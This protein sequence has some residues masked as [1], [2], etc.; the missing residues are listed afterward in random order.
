MSSGKR[1]D[2][3]IEQGFFLAALWS[4]LVAVLIFLF[5]L[6]LGLPLLRSGQIFSAL[7]RPWLPQAGLFGVYPMIVG[8][9]A[10]VFLSLYWAFPLSLGVA[11]L[12]SVI[13]PR[14]FGRF[15]KKIVL[16]MTAIPTVVYGFVGVF[17]LVPL[18]QKIFSP[19]GGMSIFTASL[20]LALLIC[21]TMILI[22]TDSFESVPRSYHEA[23]DALGGS[24]VQ[25][26]CYVLLPCARQGL[27]AG[28]V[29][30]MARAM[31]DTLI[32][33]MLAGNAVAV[34]GSFFASARTLTAHIA[35]VT[36]ADFDS[37]EF[38]T[39]FVCGLL[40]YVFTSALIVCTRHWGGEKGARF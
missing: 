29:L 35:L 7:T 19:Q 3:I 5:M 18:V 36:A 23:V 33:L 37:M 25:K 28:L 40:L 12:V 31:G 39:I 9:L 16:L 38:R 21:P 17:L 1:V 32:A 6:V 14:G 10:I 2:R 13:H 24:P 26:L 15:L 20:M 22:F 30:G 8:T 34:P 27:V 4:V 11:A